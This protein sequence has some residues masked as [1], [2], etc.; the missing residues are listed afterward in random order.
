VGTVNITASQA[1]D[2]N[3]QAATNVTRQLTVTK[4]TLTVKADNKS[5]LYG[6]ANPAL[7]I[8]YSGF[9]NGDNIAA[10]TTQASVSTTAAT[11]SLPGNYPITV[12]GAASANYSFTYVAG[13]LAIVSLNNANAT[14]ITV[15]SGT[16]SP[17]FSSGVFAY[18][19]SVAYNVDKVNITATFDATA[20][21][22]VQGAPVFSNTASQDIT[23]NP[24]NNVI[25]VV[26]TAQDGITKNT[27]TITIYKAIPPTAI[28]PMNFL[29]PNGDSK[30]EKWVIKDIELYP[31]NVVTIYDK[32]GRTIYV[33][34][35]YN[36]DWDATLRGAPLAQGTYYY[37]I[38]LGDGI[39][40][41]KG[42]ITILRNK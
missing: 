42:F 14:N 10:L 4:A 12:S 29:S 31:G 26:I 9:V 15:S 8:T 36:N 16:L 6:V 39:P 7:T 17:A 25:T 5:K 32:S 21:A 22:T 37:T 27:Y 23:L 3:N 18:T 28:A 34:K 20:T 1:G 11:T 13:S 38:E 33:K 2:A 24:G 40:V 35:G 41:I 19:A 30:N